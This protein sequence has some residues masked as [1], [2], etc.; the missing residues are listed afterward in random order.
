MGLKGDYDYYGD[1]YVKSCLRATSKRLRPGENR[2][3][4]TANG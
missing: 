2:E 1:N 4:T 3:V